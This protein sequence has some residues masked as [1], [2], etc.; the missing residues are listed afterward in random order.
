[1]LAEVK[2]LK[3]NIDDRGCLT[4]IFRL[5]DDS[6]GFGQAYITTCTQ[7]VIKAWHRHKEQVDRWYCVNGA[8]R[9]GLYNSE[10]GQSQTV[11][12]TAAYPLLVTIPAGI[13]HGF[14]PA[15]GFRETAILNIISKPYNLEHPD[16]DRVGPYKFNYSWNP[17]SR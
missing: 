13:W 15:W 14:T 6:Y 9:L 2:Q 4:E 5:T 8:A 3:V 12:L 17:E 1:M 16:E 11:I 10:T 7:G